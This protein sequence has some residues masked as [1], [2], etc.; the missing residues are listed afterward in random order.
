MS[1][2]PFSDFVRLYTTE[3]GRIR[4]G[5]TKHSSKFLHTNSLSIYIHQNF[6]FTKKFQTL[7]FVA[8]RRVR[9][10]GKGSPLVKLKDG[11]E[12]HERRTEIL[13][14][15]SSG[16]ELKGQIYSALLEGGTFSSYS[17]KFLW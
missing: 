1:E 16:K 3:V 9:S 10:K 15:K 4:K 6:E 12:D 17:E 13:L 11:K 2:P 7:L 8:R 5:T 14:F